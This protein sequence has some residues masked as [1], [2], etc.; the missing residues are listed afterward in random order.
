[1]C[2][3][4]IAAPLFPDVPAEHWAKDAVANLAAKGML[5]G[6]PDGTFKGDRAATRWEVAMVV[7][8]MLAK[9]EQ[10]NATFASKEDLEAV[11]TLV[12]GLKDELQALGVRVSDL[13]DKLSKLDTRVTDL[14]RI[15]FYGSV[16]TIYNGIGF[17]ET[18]P[19]SSMTGAFNQ[20][21]VDIING[22]PQTNGS[23][24]SQGRTR[25]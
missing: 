14:E 21:V 20:A 22:R 5:E 18:N 17:K 6:Y 9:M 24:F 1:M 13:E 7:A 16:D 2:I 3:P 19:T 10:D 15:R 11:K 23:G 8:R 25:C 4:A 12:S